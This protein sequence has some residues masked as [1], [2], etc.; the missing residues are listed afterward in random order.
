MHLTLWS[1]GAAFS[2][3]IVLNKRGGVWVKALH[4][5]LMGEPHHNMCCVLS[6]S[7]TPACI[8]QLFMRYACQ[9]H[10]AVLEMLCPVQV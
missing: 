10:P 2:T 7:M 6:A 4:L 3:Q 9:K 1:L 5:K 8:Y